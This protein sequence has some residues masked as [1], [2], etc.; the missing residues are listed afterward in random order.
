LSNSITSDRKK[1]HIELAF[2][3]KILE[4]DNRFYYE[5]VLQGHPTPEDKYEGIKI[6]NKITKSPLWVSSMT[7][8]TKMAGHINHNLARACKEFGMGMG[9]GSCRILLEEDT[10]FKDFDLRDT[11]GD[12]LPFYANLGVAQVETLLLE[13]KESLIVSLVN[14]LRADGLIIHVNPLQEYLQPEGDRFTHSPLE[15]IKCLLEKV[16]FPVIVKEVGQ[17]M[18]P[19]S[20]K[21]LMDLPL[22]AIDFGASGGT[23]FAKLELLRTEEDKAIGDN[24]LSYV[25][26][27]AGE[28]VD[29]VNGIISSQGQHKCET[30]IVSGGIKSYLDG[31]YH[32]EKLL[33][34][35]IYGMASKFLKH[36]MGDYEKLQEFTKQQLNGFALANK[37]LIPKK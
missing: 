32:T 31:Y 21:A 28:M 3:S 37:L 27:T 23:N 34:P 11:I 4:Q 19:S 6:A 17:G 8:G 1:D 18:G 30:F 16:D 36:A 22:A 25:G 2:E 24:G 13:K 15:T 12:D 10:Y 5:P 20:L 26:H 29:F 33:A 9:L 35:A 14:R 7:G